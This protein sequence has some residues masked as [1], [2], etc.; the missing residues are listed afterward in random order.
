MLQ[1]T[2]RISLK[3]WEFSHHP[4]LWFVFTLTGP[5]QLKTITANQQVILGGLLP[6][7]GAVIIRSEQ[8]V[9]LTVICAS[10][11]P[12]CYISVICPFQVQ[13]RS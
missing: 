7:K 5:K 2:S 10:A 4:L 1:S 8:A 6:K 12:H 13:A 3:G 9:P 11:S